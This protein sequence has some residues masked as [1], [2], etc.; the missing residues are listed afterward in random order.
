MAECIIERRGA[1]AD[2]TGLT[3]LPEDVKSGKT[4]LGKGSDDEQAGRMPII[5]PQTHIL[6]INGSLELTGGFYE[7]GSM[8]TQNIPTLGQQYITPSAE[9]Q[10][11]ETKGKYMEEDVVLAPLPNL[12]ASNIK[13]GAVI[14]IGDYTIIGTYEGYENND[15]MIPYYNGVFA[16]GQ[17]INYFPSFGRKAGGYY[18]GNV[19]FG[20]DNIHIENPLDTRYVT[21]AIV[22]NVPLNFDTINEI[23]LKYSLNNATGGCE[24]LLATGYVTNYIYMRPDSGSG[25]DYNEGLQDYWRREIRNTSGNIRTQTFDVSSVTGTRYIYI[26]LFL[27]TTS[28]AAVVNM[29]LRELRCK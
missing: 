7:P 6:P 25:K 3:A 13:K 26:S 19:T 12:I 11:I 14:K 24:M 2:T 9:Q 29:T 28:S 17:S 20:R 27:R 16:P 5:F 8:V 10:T 4:F 21:T 23:E 1:N 18:T 15:P 22:F